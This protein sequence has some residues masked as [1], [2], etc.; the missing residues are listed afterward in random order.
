MPAPDAPDHAATGEDP[1]RELGAQISAAREAAGKTVQDVADATRIRGSL[2]RLMESGDFAPCGGHVYARGHLRSI[3]TTLGVEPALFLARYDALAGSPPPPTAPLA[4]DRA[5]PRSAGTDPA[6]LRG[7]GG[8]TVHNRPSTWLVAAVGAALVIVVIAGI[9]FAQSGGGGHGVTATP[10]KTS[11]S[12]PRAS[13][14]HSTP[15]TSPPETVALA[16][17]NVIVK[18]HNSAS[19]VHVVDETGAVVFQGTV[20]PGQTKP[21]HAA[22]LLKFVFGYAPAISLTVNG[23]LIGEPPAGAGDVST[24]SF[25]SSNTGGANG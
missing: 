7:L 18:V 13:A 1:A 6:A 9:S 10:P 22:Q 15:Q 3:A 4:V 5:S 19:W 14:T 23:R 16:G 17:V 25:D 8:E 11:T 20:S 24:V 12:T 2:I 21:F